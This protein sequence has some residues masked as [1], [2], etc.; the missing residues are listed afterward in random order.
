MIEYCDDYV[1]G[2]LNSYLMISCIRSRP[3]KKLGIMNENTLYCDISAN[4]E[5]SMRIFY[6]ILKN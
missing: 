6:H 1:E 3:L 5:I 2:F 4:M